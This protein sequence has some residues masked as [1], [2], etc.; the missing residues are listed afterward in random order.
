MS[1][2]DAIAKDKE[3][4]RRKK[5]FRGGCAYSAGGEV[6]KDEQDD[7]VL[8]FPEPLDTSGEPGTDGFDE[9]EHPMEFMSAG[10]A[11]GGDLS[12]DMDEAAHFFHALKRRQRKF[13]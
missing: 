5:F 13:G 9:D 11:V 8:D 4:K 3:S 10:G 6:A 7:D 2:F 12:P 1:F